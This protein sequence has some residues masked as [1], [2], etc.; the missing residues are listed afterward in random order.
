MLPKIPGEPP[1][2][3]SKPIEVVRARVHPEIAGQRLDQAMAALF[4]W[5]TRASIQRLIRDG[6][7]TLVLGGNAPGSAAGERV[8]GPRASR[9]V[10]PEDVLVVDVPPR[11]AVERADAVPAELTI[12]YED[13]WL[14]AIDKP[15]GLA[16]HPT[17]SRLDGTLVNLLHGVYRDLDDPA[18]DVVPRLCHRLDRETSGL[19]LVAKDEVAHAAVRRQFEDHAVTKTYLAVVE[20]R[21]EVD[22]Q[23]VD[24][25]LGPAR[26]SAVRLKIEAREDG[27]EALTRVRVLARGKELSLVE[28]MPRTGRQHQLRVHLAALG[29]PIVGDKLYGPD[30]RWFLQGIEGS[31]D[32]EARAALRLPRQALH[33]AS[34]EL[35][36]PIRG[37]RIE[38]RCPLAADLS[39]LLEADGCA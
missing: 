22:E 26:R 6:R 8:E 14:V 12:L 21:V 9:K 36:H 20:G 30:E 7:V 29:H 35:R 1:P 19:I 10:F 33:S 31:L 18:R 38:L 28:C 34:L 17:S 32:E 25:R 13:R 39:A 24:L 23:W 27:L 2:D 5:R 15:A 4:P 3:L 37:D 16:V 11:P